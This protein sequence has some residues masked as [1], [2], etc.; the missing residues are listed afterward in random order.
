VSDETTTP[1]AQLADMARELEAEFILRDISGGAKVRYLRIYFASSYR[2]E[3][4]TELVM[5]VLALPLV[6]AHG[7]HT[8]AVYGT[9]AEV[10]DRIKSA[11]GAGAEPPL[12]A[13]RAP[14]SKDGPAGGKRVKV[15]KPAPTRPP[16]G[17]AALVGGGPRK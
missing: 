10:V 13:T 5:Q 15:R 1:R 7:L 2:F 14:A 12:P 3:D 16:R 9:D 4:V 17:G 8:A 11:L 6:R